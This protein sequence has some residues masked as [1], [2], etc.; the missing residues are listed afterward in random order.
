MSAGPLRDYDDANDDE[1]GDQRRGEQTAEIEVTS[2][3]RLVE[4]IQKP[5]VT[6]VILLSVVD[7]FKCTWLGVVAA[8]I[9]SAPEKSV[10][11]CR[12]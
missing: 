6:A 2:A 5:R 4:E 9:G 12:S 10:N 11:R 3:R 7:A 1:D 8:L